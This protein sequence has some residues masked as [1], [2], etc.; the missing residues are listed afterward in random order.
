MK[1]RQL[2]T[3][4]VA[5]STVAFLGPTHPDGGNSDAE[6]IRKVSEKTHIEI[7]LSKL[8][9][10]QATN[11]EVKG[12]ARKIGEDHEKALKDL[13]AIKVTNSADESSTRDGQ[14]DM[15]HDDMKQDD[16]NENVQSHVEKLRKLSGEE[17]DREYVH[18]MMEHHEISI[19]IFEECVKETR[20]AEIKKFAEGMLPTLKGHL[21]QA[22]RLHEQLKDMSEG[23]EA[24]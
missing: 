7:E 21:Q 13:R 1:S 19:E 6:F 24:K 3:F 18:T 14:D 2:A 23:A 5:I 8:A 10:Q 17:F 20:H 22:Q 15:K 12:F 11:E 16:M 4:V 9:V